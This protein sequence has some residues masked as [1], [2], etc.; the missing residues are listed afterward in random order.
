MT[1]AEYD[2]WRGWR[3]AERDSGASLPLL[4]QKDNDWADGYVT[5]LEWHREG[6]QDV[7][8]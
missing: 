2:F 3:A 5:C 6:D 8:S 7:N 4:N 1:I